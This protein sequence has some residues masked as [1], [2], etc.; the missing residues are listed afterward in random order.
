MKIPI[1]RLG[2]ILLTSVQ[3]DLTDAAVLQFQK[4]LVNKI[5]AVE[6]QGVAIDITS[7]EVLDSYM[8]RVFNDT[9]SM[10]Q[11]LGCEVVICGVHPS[12][13]I[14]LVEMGRNL[15]GVDCTFTLE[16]G[17]KILTER[18]ASRGDADLFQGHQ[19]AVD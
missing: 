18:I 10:A 9:A 17:M 2:K 8:V 7:L 14:T 1:L 5:V 12:I 16:Q 6:A 3:V 13:A 11:L 15:I 4:D 19:Y